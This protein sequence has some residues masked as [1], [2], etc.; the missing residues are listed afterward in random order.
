MSWEIEANLAEVQ[1]LTERIDALPEGPQR[2][3]LEEERE[4]R[5]R[6]ARRM[7]DATRSARHLEA[8]LANI[9]QQLAGLDD[10]AIKPAL[11]ESYKLVTDPSAYRRRINQRI[12]ENEATRRQALEVRRGEILA[13]LVGRGVEESGD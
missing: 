8:E 4:K 1:R 9:E 12:A 3:A 2:A 13:A 11:N 6:R 5:R 7:S 10:V